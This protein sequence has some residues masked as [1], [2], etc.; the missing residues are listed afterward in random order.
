MVGDRPTLDFVPPRDPKAP[1]TLDYGHVD[2]AGDVIDRSAATS[3]AWVD[4]F[5]GWRQVVF[6]FGLT[7][8]LFGFGDGLTHGHD[9]TCVAM[10]VGGLMIGFAV[11]V[12]RR[13]R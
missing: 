9:E 13:D 12:G 4:R 7:I 2:P 8:V 10:I 5:G 3:R 6:A 1:P 11:P